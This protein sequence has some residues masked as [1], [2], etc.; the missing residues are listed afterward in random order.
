MGCAML[1]AIAPGKGSDT[2]K[3][4]NEIFAPAYF[5]NSVFKWIH[6]DELF[7]LIK[8]VIYQNIKRLHPSG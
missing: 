8:G 2:G 6:L 4:Q 1:T 5:V 7:N 3:C